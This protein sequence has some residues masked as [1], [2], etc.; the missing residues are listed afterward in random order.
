MK[1]LPV[2]VYGTLRHGHGNYGRFLE[3]RTEKEF[4]ARA[5]DLVLYGYGI[6]FAAERSGGEVVGEL[7]I[8]GDEHYDQVLRGLD[9]L[10]GFRP[11]R[12]DD[13]M[14]LRVQREIRVS[15]DGGNTWESRTAWLYLANESIVSEF[16]DTDLI[17][18]GDWA[19]NAA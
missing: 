3:G 6:P 14:Y 12:P 19:R 17:P 1:K 8:V 7:M 16:S 15:I 9:R 13:S 18:D 5:D 2:F 11:D 10:E 4:P